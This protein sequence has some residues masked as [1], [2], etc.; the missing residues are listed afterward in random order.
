[1][2]APFEKWRRGRGLTYQQLADLIDVPQAV[3]ARRYALGK[4]MPRPETV[5]KIIQATNG[6]ITADALHE[7]CM[8]FAEEQARKASQTEAA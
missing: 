1:M 5:S 8:V 4:A 7:G 2:E 6:E 3:Q